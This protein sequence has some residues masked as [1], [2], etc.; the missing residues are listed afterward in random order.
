MACK[1]IRMQ[2]QLKLK[3]R[4]RMSMLLHLKMVN[5]SMTDAVIF[6]TGRQPNTDQLGLEKYESSP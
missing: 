2:H 4:R 5:Q 1:F 3:K 6:G